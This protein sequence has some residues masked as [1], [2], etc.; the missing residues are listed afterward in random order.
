VSLA[1]SGKPRQ[2]GMFSAAPAAA[3]GQVPGGYVGLLEY[4]RD[5]RVQRAPQLVSIQARRRR[6]LGPREYAASGL[7]QAGG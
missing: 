1:R 4:V 6:N 7:D 5:Q 2:P 3:A